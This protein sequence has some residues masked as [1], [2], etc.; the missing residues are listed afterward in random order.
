[1]RILFIIVCI[2]SMLIG[3][4]PTLTTLS[5]AGAQS[6]ATT[7]ITVTG[8]VDP[9]PVQA[10]A[11]I[12][13]IDFKPSKDK[14]TFTVMIAA[15]VPAGM[16][17]V[18]L[19]S[20]DGAS[21]QRPF[22][23]SPLPEVAEA[24]ANDDPKKPQVLAGSSVVTGKLNPTGDVDHFSI[25]ARKG[26]TIVASLL[27]NNILRSPMDGLLQLLDANGFVVAENND[28]HGLDPQVAWSVAKDGRYVVRVFAF[29]AMPD[30]SIRF[31][32][33]DACNYRLTITTGPLADHAFPSAVSLKDPNPIELR[34]WNIPDAAK[35]LV[36]KPDRLFDR[37]WITSPGLA[38]SVP[39]R[40]EPHRCL[41]ENE[42][43]D[44]A[45]PQEVATPC[46]IGGHTNAAG[47][48]D[49][50]QF[51]LK[52]GERRGIRV[53]ADAIDSPLDP[54]ARILDESGKVLNESR[55]AKG[56]ADPAEI[57]FAA[58]ADGNYRVEVRDL[59]KHGGERYV[60]RLRIADPQ[61]DFSLS[62]AVDQFTM[63]VGE[64]LEIPVTVTKQNGFNLPI[65]LRALDLPEGVTFEPGK[66]DAAKSVKLKLSAKA[67][68]SGVIRIVGVAGF[69]RTARA[70]IPN[71]ATPTESIFLTVRPAKK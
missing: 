53:E 33:S 7:N 12:K 60:Y 37:L 47:D 35:K 48:V 34:G 49:V 59:F 52:K 15:D 9:W 40:V 38:N 57:A 25:E 67:R 32:G 44:A 29:P 27:A 62:V 14:G 13:G 41:I 65:E 2:P 51:S 16:Y 64:S 5:P 56:G 54:I 68:A 46:T 39:I 61:P 30:S 26:Q 18:R 50:F 4:P 6:G 10:V 24:D 19:F 63:N 21:E 55:T 22:F 69:E 71:Y 11:S 31:F 58:P 70:T 17:W 23:V 3:A 45:R 20:A 1:M 8:T 36:L 43:N 42:P 66:P 28:T